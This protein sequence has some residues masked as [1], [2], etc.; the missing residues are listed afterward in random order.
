MK[1]KQRQTAVELVAESSSTS[2]R[3]KKWMEQISLDDQKYLAD[4][5]LEIMKTPG[6]ALYVV[7][8]K[9]KDELCLSVSHDTIAKTLKEVIA[10]GKSKA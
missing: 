1:K 5:I 9:L 4:V 6:V 8:K 10:N 2:S 3:G 7:A